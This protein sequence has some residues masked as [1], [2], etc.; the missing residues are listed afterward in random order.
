LNEIA[1]ERSFEELSKAGFG[2]FRRLFSGVNR[3]NV[4]VIEGG[5]KRSHFGKACD[6]DIV[7]G[8]QVRILLEKSNR[9]GGIFA[10]KKDFPTIENGEDGSP[11][12][13]PVPG[14]SF[15]LKCHQFLG[16]Q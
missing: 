11:D 3:E 4:G 5:A 7:P 8:T 16:S 15:H 1:V 6:L 14:S 2:G 12:S 9:D 13:N 10:A